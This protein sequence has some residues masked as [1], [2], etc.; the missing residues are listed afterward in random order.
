LLSIEFLAD[1]ASG[2]RIALIEGAEAQSVAN[3]N[4]Q[5]IRPAFI[6]ASS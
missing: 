1:K 6:A 5:L 4:G 3:E 2:I